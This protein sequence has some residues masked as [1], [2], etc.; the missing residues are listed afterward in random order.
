MVLKF[1]GTLDLTG[2]PSSRF[3]KFATPRRIRHH[4]R[5]SEPL[6]L[7][8]QH[9]PLNVQTRMA[10]PPAL[11]PGTSDPG[12]DL[13]NS[14]NGPRR[15]KPVDGLSSDSHVRKTK[16]PFFAHRCD[17]GTRVGQHERPTSV[18]D[19]NVGLCPS[20]LILPAKACGPRLPGMSFGLRSHLHRVVRCELSPSSL[21]DC[22]SFH[23]QAHVSLSFH[24]FKSIL[25]QSSGFT[26]DSPA[27]ESTVFSRYRPR[28]PSVATSLLSMDMLPICDCVQVHLVRPPTLHHW[29]C[30]SVGLLL[31]RRCHT[32]ALS[33]ADVGTLPASGT[34]NRPGS[35]LRSNLSHRV[36]TSVRFVPKDPFVAKRRTALA[37]DANNQR[38]D[39]LRPG[40]LHC[41]VSETSR[42]TS[43]SSYKPRTR[44]QWWHHF[45]CFVPRIRHPPPHHHGLTIPQKTKNKWS[46][47]AHV[48]ACVSRPNNSDTF[49]F[50]RR[51]WSSPLT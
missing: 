11:P 22:Q 29:S 19:H 1:P 36:Q 30:R 14:P 24:G 26:T 44:W 34:L 13:L 33:L 16:T 25:D 39:P 35:S 37:S 40:D 21:P 5:L 46:A 12:F 23:L 17:T 9:R 28:S 45:C 27:P 38:T 43:V 51:F 42:K 15:L 49:P 48:V 18:E 7:P 8:C 10:H 2:C 4:W 31:H 6:R 50:G 47:M 20:L 32:V 41:K 3:T